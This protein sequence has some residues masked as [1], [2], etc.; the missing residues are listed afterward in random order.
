[1]Q[2]NFISGVRFYLSNI[3]TQSRISKQIYALI[4]SQSV[5]SMC[6]CVC[7]GGRLGTDLCNVK[8][9]FQNESKLST[10]VSIIRI[11]PFRGEL[12]END[13]DLQGIVWPRALRGN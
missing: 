9:H 1:M 8:M 5:C 2:I 3:R 13:T 12:S 4:I 11:T 7:G 10:H 6:E